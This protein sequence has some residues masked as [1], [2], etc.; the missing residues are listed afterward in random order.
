[1]TQHELARGAEAVLIRENDVVRK[2]RVGKGYRIPA[3]DRTLREA[4]TKQEAKMLRAG[5]R[6]G[7]ATPAIVHEGS[8]ELVLDFVGGP[9]VKDIFD[10]NWKPLAPRIGSAVAK[11]HDAGIVHGDL[12]TSNMLLGGEELVL[13]DFGLAFFSARPEDK[14]VDLHLLEQALD[15]AHYRVADRAWPLILKVYEE[16]YGGAERVLG[17]LRTL[18]RRGRYKDRSAR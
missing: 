3:L 2:H 17:A 14:A 12:T 9:R 8:D 11:L 5:R 10:E 6:A 7:V 15:S 18:E 13:I 16:N 1:M 4:R